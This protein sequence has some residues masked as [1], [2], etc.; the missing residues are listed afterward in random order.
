ML[1]TDINGFSLIYHNWGDVLPDLTVLFLVSEIVGK[2]N[3]EQQPDP[4]SRIKA[5]FFNFIAYFSITFSG[6][7][8]VFLADIFLIRKLPDNVR[9][10]IWVVVWLLVVGLSF[11][12]AWVI[13]KAFDNLRKL[14]VRKPTAVIPSD[15]EQGKPKSEIH[16]EIRF[17]TRV[18]KDQLFILWNQQREMTES[19]RSLNRQLA[20]VKAWLA[21][22]FCLLSL[23]WLFVIIVVI[24][25]L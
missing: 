11:A 19:M 6:I 9:Y 18:E 16:S 4:L 8:G 5:G 22:L 7:V 10:L 12:L 21:G 1:I 2:A 20:S 23:F 3:V 15:I 24:K 25:F 14:L 17:K 13:G